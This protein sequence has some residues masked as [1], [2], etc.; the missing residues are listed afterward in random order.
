MKWMVKDN[1]CIKF[2]PASF[3]NMLMAG[4]SPSVNPTAEDV[5]LICLSGPSGAWLDM[6]Q[7]L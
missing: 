1:N 6:K 4:M 7:L 3:N 5:T 2:Q